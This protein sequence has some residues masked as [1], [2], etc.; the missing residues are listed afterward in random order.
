MIPKQT[1]LLND[2]PA[3]AL[4][5]EVVQN[6]GADKAGLKAGDILTKFDGTDLT[7]LPESSTLSS[8]I[9]KK[10]VGDKV[11]VDYVRDDK[12]QTTVITLGESG[13]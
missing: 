1:A 11:S 10:K 8:L 7:A 13:E 3:G 2:V 6:S 5:M 12:K 9:G 4:V